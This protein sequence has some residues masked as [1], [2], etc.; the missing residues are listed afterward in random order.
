MCYD[1]DNTRQQINIT[2]DTAFPGKDMDPYRHK[3]QAGLRPEPESRM[4]LEGVDP[5]LGER[6]VFQVKT[7]KEIIL[8]R[9]VSNTL[10]SPG[11]VS[12]HLQKS[13]S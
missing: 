4:D 2:G 3:N 8:R 11:P 7:W 6:R 9:A 10:Q 1:T 13:F 12:P 5:M